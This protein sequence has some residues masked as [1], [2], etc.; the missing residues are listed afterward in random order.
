[1]TKYNPW[2]VYRAN[3]KKYGWSK[4]KRKIYSKNEKKESPIVIS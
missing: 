4:K 2:A 3:A 1:M